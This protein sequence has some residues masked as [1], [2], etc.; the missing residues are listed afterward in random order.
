MTCSVRNS[1]LE[2]HDRQ[3]TTSCRRH[4]SLDVDIARPVLSI[5]RAVPDGAWID[6]GKQAQQ[7]ERRSSDIM[8]CEVLAD[9]SLL[10]W[11]RMTMRSGCCP[12][13]RRWSRLTGKLMLVAVRAV[14]RLR[15]I[16]SI[17]SLSHASGKACAPC[18]FNKTGRCFDGEYCQSCH[19]SCGHCVNPRLR[20]RARRGVRKPT[21][22]SDSTGTCS[23]SSWPSE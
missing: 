5:D 18:R 10:V 14:L 22:H 6:L 9:R 3:P 21:P 23:D 8:C 7:Q 17:G 15:S 13:Q 1:F 12:V 20:Q 16:P 4:R 11:K 19:Y 2:F